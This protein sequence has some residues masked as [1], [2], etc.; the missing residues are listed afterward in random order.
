MLLSLRDAET[1]YGL[2]ENGKWADELKWCT[3]LAIPAE[4][5][6]SWMNTATGGPTTHI[7]CNRDM[8]PALGRALQNIISR[9][10]IGQLKTFDGCFII[11]CI[12]GESTIS[13]HSYALAVDINASTNKLGTL[14]DMSDDLAKCFTDEGFI[15]G[16]TFGRVDKMHFQL[17]AW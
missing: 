17:A 5:S 7:Y 16:G 1:R 14:G 8:A 12:R 6:V 15:W 11:R 10:L 4:L 9:G 2:I 3:V 13:V